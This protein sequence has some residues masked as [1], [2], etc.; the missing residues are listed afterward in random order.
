MGDV[1]DDDPGNEGAT[2][3]GNLVHAVFDLARGDLEATRQ[4][5]A[6][7]SGGESLRGP[8]IQRAPQNALQGSRRPVQRRL[9]DLNSAGG[10]VQ[11]DALR[12]GDQAADLRV[13]DF[14]AFERVYAAAVSER[15][16]EDGF[17]QGLPDLGQHGVTRGRKMAAADVT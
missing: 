7:R 12:D 2:L 14:P 11:R 9:G 1:A 5:G 4:L 15:L 16:P 17:A 8:P 10:F 3:G 6:G 13:G